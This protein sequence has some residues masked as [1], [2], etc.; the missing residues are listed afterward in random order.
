MTQVDE[1][2]PGDR[3]FERIYDELRSLARRRLQQGLGGASL[4]ATGLIHEVWLK[5]S[6]NAELAR[7]G[8]ERYFAI[9]AQAMRWI[10]VDRARRR[11]LRRD[12]T[13]S[14]GGV[15]R[16]V[17]AEAERADARLLDLDEALER[18]ERA[19]PRKAEVVLHRHFAGLSVEDTAAALGLSP[20]TVKREWQFARAWLLRELEEIGDSRAAPAEPSE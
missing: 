10:L 19:H 4:Q 3:T 16:L 15:S 1:R 6:E 11:R 18:L 17:D 14:G 20:A 9:A 13:G 8:T 2:H 12:E 7:A 5:L